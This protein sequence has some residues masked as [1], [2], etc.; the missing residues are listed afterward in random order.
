MTNYHFFFI[1]LVKSQRTKNWSTPLGKK[2]SQKVGEGCFLRE[3]FFFLSF[4]IRY[5]LQY[6]TFYSGAESLEY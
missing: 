5:F 2:K 6:T 3:M 4:R 1:M